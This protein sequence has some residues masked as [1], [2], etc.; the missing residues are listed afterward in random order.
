MYN[1]IDINNTEYRYILF[2]YVVYRRKT[3]IEIRNLQK[4]FGDNLVLTDIN[5]T[6]PDKEIYGL[7]GVS[8]AGK[9][10]LLRCINGLESYDSGS[11]KINGTEI[12]T[13]KGR[14]LLSFRS[15]IGMIFQQFLLMERMT[16]YQNVAFPL[17]CHGK[18]KKEIDA[19][20]TELLSLVE[21][22]DKRN[23]KPRELSG[24]QKQRVAIARALALNPDILLCDEA[25]SAL[26]PNITI[27][28]L[29]LLKKINHELGLTII[30]VTHQMEVVKQICTR[31]SILNK[32]R[33]AYTGDVKDVFLKN[34][35]ALADLMS[36][37]TDI[38]LPDEGKNIE[39][40]FN[41]AADKK[42]LS[43][44]AIKTNVDYSII[45][46][47]LDKYYNGSF[48]SYT[49]NIPEDGFPAISRYLDEK[50]I[51]WRVIE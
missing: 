20:V 35:E 7:I 50:E 36:E 51:E 21:L 9:S 28:I 11:L 49:I 25:T 24:G 26:D 19:R 4:S 33:L 48:G 31:V 2:L 42:L 8:G 13:L 45:W 34:P 15:R 47:K 27:S 17:K 5:V 29:E 32:G 40:L 39:I 37:K 10:T 38:T 1:T 43:D 30:V 23:A 14:D 12:S 6:I 44:M 46:S 3:M 16:V 41:A 22:T 18:T